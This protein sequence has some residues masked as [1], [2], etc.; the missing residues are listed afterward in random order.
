VNA[1]LV[2]NALGMAI[3]QRNPTEALR[4]PLEST[5]FTPWAFTRRAIDSGL[6]LSMGSIGDC[7]D[8]D[9]PR[10]LLRSA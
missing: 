3:G 2:T 9:D 1:A 6:L 7:Y 10:V 8:C 4:R 5:Q